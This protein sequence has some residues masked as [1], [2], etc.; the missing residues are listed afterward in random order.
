MNKNTG[1]TIGVLFV[2]FCCLYTCSSDKRKEKAAIWKSGY[3][4]GYEDGREGISK[5]SI[6]FGPDEMPP[7]YGRGDEI[8][9]SKSDY[10]RQ[11]EAY[12]AGWRDFK[13]GQPYNDNPPE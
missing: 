4:E 10:K 2:L 5:S 13:M 6:H 1:A 3:Y 7:Q 11:Y 9:P 8:E 12:L